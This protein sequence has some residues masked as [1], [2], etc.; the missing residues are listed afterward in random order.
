MPAN[1]RAGLSRDFLMENLS[2]AMEARTNFPWAASVPERMYFNDVLPYA[3]LDEPRDPWRADFY[4]MASNIVRDCKTAAEA[5]QALNR[6]LFDQ[7][8]VHYNVARK[9]NN[10]SPKESIEQGKATC[11]GLS[12]IL[13]DA[14]RAVGV[15]A[16]IAG[17]PEWAQ[18]EGN[19][20]WVEIWDGDWFFT[21]ADEYDKN[22]L[23]RA[24]FNSDAAKTVRSADPL[25]QI[26]AT[27]WRRTAQY[28]PMSWDLAS[29]DVSGVNVS[30]RYAG[31]E[32]DTNDTAT[33][34]HVRLRDKA[35]GDRLLS[36]VELLSADGTVLSRDH[37]RAGTADMN[38][39]PDF[40]LPEHAASAIFR[41]TR[42][43]E[44]RENTDFLHVVREHAHAGFRLER[45]DAGT[46]GGFSG[47]TWLARSAGESRRS[48]GF[49]FSQRRSG[50]TDV[51]GLGRCFQIPGRIGISGIVR[52][53]NRHWRQGP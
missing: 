44:A 47:G 29:R 40:K 32:V 14:C 38:D 11:T 30:A 46:A 53:K 13:V 52:G 42:D 3:S 33:V 12:I 35:D 1:D 18:K 34:V 5:A 37:T 43:G 45:T 16:R 2:L 28:F 10:Q 26:Y 25:H 24:W 49:C 48:A 8:K 27:S 15:P 41:F 31:L 19:H 39:M 22:G 9:R 6:E 51:T 20:T 23:N 21:G 17:V 4:P 50:A 36:E 7:I